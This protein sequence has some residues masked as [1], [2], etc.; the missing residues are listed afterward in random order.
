MEDRMAGV[1]AWMRSNVLGLIAIFIALSGSAYAASVAKNSVTSK[2]IKNGAVQ[3]ADVKD[4]GLTAADIDQAALGDLT[5]PQGPQGQQGPPGPQGPEGPSGTTADGSV[6]TPKLATD[7][8][9]QP[10]IANDA[11]GAAEL[12]NNAVD[13]NALQIDSVDTL[14]LQ[15]E[16]VTSDKLGSGAVQSGHFKA[17]GTLSIDWPSLSAGNCASNNAG[18]TG[19]L[20]TDLVVINAHNLPG[21]WSITAATA[22]GQVQISVCSVGGPT[23][24]P[25][26]LNHEYLLID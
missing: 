2:S 7:A 20:A 16:V 11:V 8:V 5:G 6:T 24:D 22:A 18:V 12:E 19:A 14:A 26:P 1:G 13:T 23:L 21:S 25:G 9:T 10:K 15:D 4:G 3:S 17:N